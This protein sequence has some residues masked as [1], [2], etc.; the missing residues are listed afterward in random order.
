MKFKR[1]YEVFK[2]E[3]ISKDNINFENNNNGFFLGNP[4]AKL[5]ISLVSNPYCGF[6][7]NAHEISEKLLKNYPNQI[8]LQIRFN[9]SSEKEDEKL[10]Q[11]IGSLK[12]IYEIKGNFEFLKSLRFWFEN[13]DEKQF[14]EKD[15]SSNYTNLEEL[16]KI[17]KENFI[18]GLNFT[19]MF[20]I[21][22][23]HFPDKYEREDIFYF[24]DELLEDEDI[25]K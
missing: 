14:N 23:Y 12:N 4:D 19:P 18:H 3:L 9:F 15:S 25:L 1:N 20:L 11:L 5:H 24:I 6:C 8:S 10:T 22:G 2:R 7:K 16:E 17:G 21:N 13:K